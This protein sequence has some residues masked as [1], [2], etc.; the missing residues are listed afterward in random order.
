MEVQVLAG[1]T[2]KENKLGPLPG[3]ISKVLGFGFRQNPNCSA[4]F[5]CDFWLL[6]LS[7]LILLACLLVTKVTASQR[8][9][10]GDP[11]THPDLYSKGSSFKQKHE[12][13]VTLILS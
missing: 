2:K 7:K 11:C 1:K 10:G 8:S 5:Q 3:R 9:E 4:F 13:V 12:E 6:I